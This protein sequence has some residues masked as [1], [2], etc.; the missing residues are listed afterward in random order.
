MPVCLWGHALQEMREST[1]GA[2]FL[3]GRPRWEA[4]SILPFHCT[5]ING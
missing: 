4:K 3:S 1:I 2:S 5:A